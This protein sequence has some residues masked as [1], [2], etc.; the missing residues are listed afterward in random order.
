P[1]LS[2]AEVHSEISS[3]TAGEQTKPIKIASYYA[4]KGGISFEDPDDLVQKAIYRVL[5]GKREWPRDLGKLGFLA[6][7]SLSVWM[8]SSLSSTEAAVRID[9]LR[10]VSNP[11]R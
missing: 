4:W 7:V 10:S 5:A 2:Q 9:R 1:P 11:R 3:L 6:G 8:S